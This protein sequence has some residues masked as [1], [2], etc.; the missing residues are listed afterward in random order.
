MPFFLILQEKS[1]T[2]STSNLDDTFGFDLTQ[3]DMVR[4][5]TQ[6]CPSNLAELDVSFGPFED[7]N[8]SFGFDLSQEVTSEETPTRRTAILSQKRLNEWHRQM[9]INQPKEKQDERDLK[10]RKKSIRYVGA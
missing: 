5:S 4:N 3:E 7:Q 1:Q 2:A 8:V 10:E 6:I 9:I